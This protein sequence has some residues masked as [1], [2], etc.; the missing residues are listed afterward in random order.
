MTRASESIAFDCTCC[1]RCCNSPPRLSLPEI[2][3]FQHVFIGSLAVSRLSTHGDPQRA[4]LLDRIALRAP[5]PRGATHLALTPQGYGYDSEAFCPALAADFRCSLHGAG[6]PTQC[7]AVPLDPFAADAEQQAVLRERMNDS[8]FANA[9]CLATALPS[10]RTTLVDDTSI[11]D[12]GHAAALERRRA[13]LSLDVM[14]WGAAVAA[15][16]LRDME[17][18]LGPSGFVAL[19]LVPALL[20]VAGFSAAC[21]DRCLDFLQA[22]SLLIETALQR[23]RA[24]RRADDRPMSRRLQAWNDSYRDLRRILDQPPSAWL[25]PSIGRERE[26]WLGVL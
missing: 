16:V 9:G 22:Q 10:S 2:F 15:H 8:I 14:I 17:A 13:A 26:A 1:G 7:Q 12:V 11:V 23:A 19:P 24:L 4:A 20:V 6:K 18:A 21:R 3:R 25:P 5:G